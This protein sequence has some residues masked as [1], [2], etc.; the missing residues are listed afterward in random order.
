MPIFSS[1]IQDHVANTMPQ[2][3]YRFDA[4]D[5]VITVADD[6]KLDNIWDG[7]GSSDTW[8]YPISDG[9]G[10]NGRIYEKV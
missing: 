10:D 6:A 3:Y 7:G 4:V 8:I 9:E 2:P 1:T 5:D